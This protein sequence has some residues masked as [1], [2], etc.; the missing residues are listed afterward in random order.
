MILRW[1]GIALLP[2]LPLL[3]LLLLLLLPQSA[4]EVVTVLI[5]RPGRLA[6]LLPL[7]LRQPWLR[8]RG[9]L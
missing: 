5:L 8:Q 4:S 1:G 3:L 7:P 6:L 9:W 2:L